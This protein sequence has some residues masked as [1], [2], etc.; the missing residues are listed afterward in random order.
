[1]IKYFFLTICFL[2]FTNT[3]LLAQKKGYVSIYLG[4]FYDDMLSETFTD[5]DVWR[6]LIPVTS[7]TYQVIQNN[8]NSIYKYYM[9]SQSGVQAGLEYTKV[10]GNNFQ[11]ISGIR[12]SYRYIAFQNERL[13][14]L[15]TT[16]EE[17]ITS[18]AL[19]L[20]DNFCENYVSFPRNTNNN[21]LIHRLLDLQIPIVLEYSL[22]NQMSYSLGTYFSFPVRNRV[23][24]ETPHSRDLTIE[25]AFDC[26]ALDYWQIDDSGKGI[27]NF[28]V[29][30]QAGARYPFFNRLQLYLGL[31]KELI[32]I[33]DPTES[34]TK[35]LIQS[36][37]KYHY[38]PIS[39]HT[40]LV[41]FFKSKD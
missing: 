1:M 15:I 20:A 32:N 34:P 35:G 7:E 2:S 27:R 41:Y 23:K 11:W 29:G 37:K 30:L 10:L 16:S 31:S 14:F 26:D 13:S 12:L 19:I 9:L 5:V 25:E 18:K 6:S 40:K 4:G 28:N 33:F 39:F 17:S 3:N 22:R 8:R 21:Y 24:E 38:N 36:G